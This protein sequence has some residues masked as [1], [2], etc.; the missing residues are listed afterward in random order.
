MPYNVLVDNTNRS[1]MPFNQYS[2]SPIDQRY[3]LLL[4]HF[5]LEHVQE[6]IGLHSMP[7]WTFACP[8]C[9]PL[10]SKTVKKKQRKA[11]LLWNPVQNSW[12]F[13]CARGGSVHC[14][15]GKTLSNL[16]SAL[17]PELGEAYRM[18]RW[19]SGTTGL[20]HNCANPR[21][22]RRFRHSHALVCNASI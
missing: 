6:S 12:V 5:Y 20:G 1:Y 9:G 8:F 17:N 22:A 3:R 18:D 10:Q 15:S 11:A 16:I 14:S 4:F 21:F 2:E 13:T 19:H 7:K